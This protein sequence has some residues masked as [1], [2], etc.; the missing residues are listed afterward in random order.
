[1][2]MK[3]KLKNPLVFI[4]PTRLCI[5]NL[6]PKVSDGALKAICFKSTAQ[7]KAAKIIEVSQH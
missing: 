3:A 5:H 7:G 2:Q 1:M 4:S 6:P